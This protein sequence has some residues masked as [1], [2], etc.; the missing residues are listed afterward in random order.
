MF[1]ARNMVLE[2]HSTQCIE[3]DIGLCFLK[4]FFA[5]IYSRSGILPR[6]IETEASVTDWDFRGKVVLRNLSDRQVE[7]ETGDRIVQVVFQKVECPTF[8]KVSDF[9]DSVTERNE[10]GLG[11]TEVRQKNEFYK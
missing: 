3:T 5:K 11:S 2:P 10:Q 1:S 7:L 9:N 8:T 4:K 6:S